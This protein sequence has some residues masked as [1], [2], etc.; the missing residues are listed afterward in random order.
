MSLTLY[1]PIIAILDIWKTTLFYEGESVVYDGFKSRKGPYIA[2]S[3]RPL[4]NGGV[5]R[6]NSFTRTKWHNFLRFW[7]CWA[8][9]LLH[10]SLPAPAFKRTLQ[11][12]MCPNSAAMCRGVSPICVTKCILYWSSACEY[13]RI[14][15]S[16]RSV[17]QGYL[18][19]L[20][21]G[22]GKCRKLKSLLILV[23][24]RA[25]LFQPMSDDRRWEEDGAKEKDALNFWKA[26]HGLEIV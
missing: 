10:L 1:V 18:C 12:S 2:S 9:T 14:L 19:T 20:D 11:T 17:A 22:L 8:L 6:H 15:P 4:A 7:K 5:H 23:P 13:R 26:Y 21:K 24:W 16:C 25:S 3:E